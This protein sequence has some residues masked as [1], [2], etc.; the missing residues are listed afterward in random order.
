MACRMKRR[1][2]ARNDE[3]IGVELA[4]RDEFGEMP[5]AA[6]GRRSADGI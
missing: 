1:I 4:D 5:R 6:E 3:S 2:R